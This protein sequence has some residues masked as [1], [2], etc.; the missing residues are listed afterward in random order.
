MGGLFGKKRLFGGKNRCFWGVWYP[1]F[2]HVFCII[3]RVFLKKVAF[4]GLIRSLKQRIWN[5]LKSPFLGGFKKQGT[6]FYI[7]IPP[8][9][10]FFGVFLGVECVNVFW[11]SPPFPR[12]KGSFWTRFSAYAKLTQILHEQVPFFEHVWKTLRRPYS[13]HFGEAFFKV[14]FN[15]V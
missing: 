4:W 8:K 15:S 10:A 13:G 1:F 11:N 9:M 6:D 2:E 3:F 12:K 14:V 5:T 7:E